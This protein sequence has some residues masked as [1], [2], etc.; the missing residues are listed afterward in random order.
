MASTSLPAVDI[1]EN[2]QPNL[3]ASS[4]IPFFFSVVTVIL[5]FWCRW[6]NGAGFWLDDYLVLFA[7]ACAI[8]LAANMLWWI[9]RAL[10][11]HVQTFGA[12]VTKYFAIGLFTAELT[13]TGVIIFVKFSILALYW[14]IFN[15]SGSIKLPIGIL[16]A[17]VLMWGIAVFFLTLLQCIPTRGYWDKTIEASC[18][19]DSQMFLFAISIPNILIDVTLL[20]LPVPYVIRLNVSKSQKR[21]IISM[22]LLGGLYGIWAV[23]EADFAIISACLPTLRPLWIAIRPKRL[24]PVPS[25]SASYRHGIGTPPR[26]RNPRSLGASLLK[27]RADEEEDTRPFSALDGVA[28]AT[29]RPTSVQEP[30]RTKTAISIPLSN[31]RAQGTQESSAIRVDN[32]WDVEYSQR[33]HPR[34]NM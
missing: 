17:A 15:K 31:V 25:N 4:T 26:K 9:P 8:G 2:R 28:D 14:R 22:F 18:N 32:T 33:V 30:Q 10:G 7:L 6:V 34:D 21:A 3:Y 16:T 11:R 27:S 12:D 19:V 13:Y 5:R 24:A 1:S 20:V 29:L 23:V